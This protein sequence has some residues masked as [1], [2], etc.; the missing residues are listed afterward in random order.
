M[1]A[2]REDFRR[3]S[4]HCQIRRSSLVGG[5]GR[6]DRRRE[7]DNDPHR[8]EE[9]NLCEEEEEEGIMIHIGRKGIICA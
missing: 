5:E 9:D 6:R 8:G 1:A 7:E 4:D 2:E 3:H